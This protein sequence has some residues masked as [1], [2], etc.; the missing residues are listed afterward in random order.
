MS[1]DIPNKTVVKKLLN[2]GL[3]SES[4]KKMNNKEQLISN[5]LGEMLDVLAVAYDLKPLAALDFTP[6]GRSKL[7][8][9]NVVLKNKIIEFCV[10]QGVKY[11]HYTK[12][13][14]MYLK[15]IFFLPKNQQKAINLMYV[16]WK[17]PVFT[18]DP[19]LNNMYFHFYIG[20]S[21]GYS[22]KNIQYFLEKN[23]QVSL[24][25]EQLK[26]INSIF[27]SDKYTLEDFSPLKIKIIEKIKPLKN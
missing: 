12:T 2:E 9:E 19:L 26:K 18:D 7:K 4:K 21:L 11:I 5:N 24:N 10:Q 27:E 23:L 22:K 25:E 20:R 6:Y 14:G 13:G 16:L 15:S 8:K 1:F 3:V 17:N